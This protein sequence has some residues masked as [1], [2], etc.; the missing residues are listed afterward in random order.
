MPP[1]QRKE[2][3]KEANLPEPGG[4]NINLNGGFGSI[5]H[6]PSQTLKAYLLSLPIELFDQIL[7]KYPKAEEKHIIANTKTLDLRFSVR[8]GVLRT[9]SQ[10]CKS[11]RTE[12][13]PKLWELVEVCYVEKYDDVS[14]NKVLSRNLENTSRGLIKTPEIAKLV[15]IYTVTF[16][17]WIK[18]TTLSLFVQCLQNLPNLHTL[19]VLH[20]PSRIATALKDAFSHVDLPQIH[21]LILPDCAHDILRSCSGARNITCN[22]HDGEKLLDTIY[23]SG[24]DIQSLR[25]VGTSQALLKRLP[26]LVPSLELILLDIQPYIQFG[27]YNSVEPK[28]IY[29]DISIYQHLKELNN[30]STIELVVSESMSSEQIPKG[31]KLKA[32]VNAARNLLK[33]SQATGRKSVILRYKPWRYDER[34]EIFSV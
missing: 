3:K 15:K 18:Y 8:T 2:A 28:A 19:Q 13:L 12:C 25:N 30:L 16:P 6:S 4:H 22:E 14:F 23:D 34:T 11:L 21:T 32:H 10:T 20:A 24:L 7:S 29:Y 27:D 17:P 5:R 26:I 1:K 31:T 9:L 33:G